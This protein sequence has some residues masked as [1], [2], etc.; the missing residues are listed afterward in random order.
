MDGTND[1]ILSDEILIG[2][3]DSFIFR[4]GINIVLVVTAPHV[5]NLN[6]LISYSNI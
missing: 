1:P 3:V 6:L 2:L 4:D 5:L